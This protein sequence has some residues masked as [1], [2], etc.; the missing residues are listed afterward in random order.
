MKTAKR[1]MKFIANCDFRKAVTV[2][3]N[4]IKAYAYAMSGPKVVKKAA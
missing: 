2:A 1:I 4:E 3:R